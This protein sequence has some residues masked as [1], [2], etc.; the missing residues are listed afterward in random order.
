MQNFRALLIMVLEL[1][2]QNSLSNMS[3]VIQILIRVQLGY[4]HML[5]LLT[6]SVTVVNLT[7]SRTIVAIVFF[8]FSVLRGFPR[9]STLR[10][11]LL[12]YVM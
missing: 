6:W 9:E 11:I 3:I 8:T 12:Y 10:S 2:S 5:Y 4:C 1:F 7:I